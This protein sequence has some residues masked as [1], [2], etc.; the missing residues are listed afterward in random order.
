M[1][2]VR[3]PAQFAPPGSCETWRGY[4]P[5]PVE[6]HV[7]S[8]RHASVTSE[9]ADP[10]RFTGWRSLHRIAL[11]RGRL[12]SLASTDARVHLEPAHRN[13]PC[14]ALD[15]R[16]AEPGSRKL[17][18]VKVATY[19]EPR[20]LPSC[21]DLPKSTMLSHRRLVASRVATWGEVCSVFGSFGSLD[22][23]VAPIR[24]VSAHGTR[25]RSA[26]FLQARREARFFELTPR[27]VRPIST[28]R[29]T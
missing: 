16:L 11:H 7:L 28:T 3:D 2:G 21:S 29:S 19:N 22:E 1:R 15:V 18:P 24:L 26:S 25:Q 10:P 8:T 17:H 6:V 4:S 27:C 9:T 20:R 14:D 12:V 13:T 5:S 23:Q